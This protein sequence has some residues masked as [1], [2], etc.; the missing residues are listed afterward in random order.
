[1]VGSANSLNI[2]QQ[3]VVEFDGVITFTP[4]NITN[5]GLVVATI[6]NR[7]SSLGVATN[8]Q[9]PIGSTGVDPV[10]ATI[11]QG[12]NITIT[13]G[14]GTIQL[15][16][17]AGGGLSLGAFGS[18]PN[19]NGLSLSTGVLNMQPADGTNPG[20]VSTATQNFAGAK[21]FNTSA[22]SA[23]FLSISGGGGIATIQYPTSAT[24]F[25]FNLPTSAG[26]SGY[27]LTSGGGGS[28]NMTWTDPATVSGVL[29][30]T[31]NSGGAESPSAGNFNILGGTT[32]LTFAGTAATE[33]LTG[34]LVIANGGTNATSFTQTNGIVTYNGTSLVNYAGP[35]LSSGGIM[36][37]TTQP[38]FSAYVTTAITNATGD[39]TNYQLGT[40]AL[41]E[42]FD[43][44]N[45]F[46]TNGTFTAP[47][48]GIYL[49]GM[50]VVCTNLSVGHTDFNNF[51]QVTGTSAKVYNGASLNPFVC[52]GTGSDFSQVTSCLA[53]MTA[54]DTALAFV[55]V[56]GSTKTV[57]ISGT[58]AGNENTYFF[59]FLVC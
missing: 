21:V 9:I 42:A 39:G 14:A 25:N 28:T 49:L 4:P 45:N 40:S 46:N 56:N 2:S 30:I 6:N 44:G 50:G 34:T 23:S 27:F 1:M 29:T 11:T 55:A 22:A 54:G 59:G 24:S 35:Q 7:L 20:G 38:S 58:G 26:T 37:N 31:G 19:A 33:T 52:K 5:H 32:G 36:T 51:I 8:G 12:S 10:L 18:T 3:G 43:R 13:N 57:T 47:D 15:D 48:T 16:V 53:M 17:A 41:T